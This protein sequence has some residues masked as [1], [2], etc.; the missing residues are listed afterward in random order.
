MRTYGDRCGIARALDAVGDRWALLVVRELLLGP[1][2]FTD[3]RAGLRKVSPDVLAQ[4]LRDL[5]AHGVVRR[6]T[7]PPP[8]AS[9]V[10]ELTDRGRELKPVILELGRWGSREPANDGPLGPDAAVI[11]L[12]TMFHGDLAGTFELRLG[13]RVFTLR[14]EKGE[15]DAASGP[16]TDP[17]AVIEGE[18][19]TLA[20]VLWHG[21]EPAA[22][23]ITGDRRA[24]RRFLRAFTP[25]ARRG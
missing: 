18:P 3:L 17:D 9:Q 15:L 20:S 2:R 7:L 1:K 5:E 19:G 23:H 14:A 4:R 22:L 11:A 24:A 8:A 21:A 6:A 25:P 10:Y 13:G 12:M 16:A